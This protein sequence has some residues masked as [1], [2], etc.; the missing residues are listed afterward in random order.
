MLAGSSI[1]RST[2][3]KS[4]EMEYPHKP[5]C[6]RWFFIRVPGSARN[7]ELAKMIELAS[8]PYNCA[9]DS[10]AFIWRNTTWLCVHASSKTRFANCLSWY[11]STRFNAPSRDSL[12]PV[13]ISMVADPSGSRSI[14]YWIATIGSSTEPWL[15]ERI[16][17]FFIDCGDARVFPRPMNC[18]RSVS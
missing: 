12:I 13:T 9:S 18:I 8:R 6:P 4:P 14:W 5:D 17:K 11:F 7:D 2:I 10:L 3:G 1:C 16:L 15:P